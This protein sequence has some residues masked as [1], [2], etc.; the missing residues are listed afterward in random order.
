VSPQLLNLMAAACGSLALAA[1]SYF[2]TKQRERDAELR[3]ENLDHYK[4]YV[5]SLSGIISGQSS[6]EGQK[7]YA[8]AFNNLHL[9]APQAVIDAL[10][11]YQ[12]ELDPSNSKRSR[13]RQLEMY[14][15]LMF[16][17]RRDLNVKPKDSRTFEA[18]LWGYGGSQKEME[19]KP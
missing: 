6:L 5:A 19:S 2:F 7:E 18:W 8:Q 9:F 17:I 10:H 15:K 4:A 14:T 1:L 11:E 12:R 13:E 3:R 16:E